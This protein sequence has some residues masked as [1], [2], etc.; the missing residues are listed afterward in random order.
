MPVHPHLQ[1]RK[2]IVI[3]FFLF[4]LLIIALSI[5]L[6]FI[7]V[8]YSSEYQKRAFEQRTRELKV[9]PRRGIIYDRRGRELAMCQSSMCFPETESAKIQ[10]ETASKYGL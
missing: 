8:V 6:F 3:L 7:Q 2:R 5:R 9:E 4:F 10:P 1:A